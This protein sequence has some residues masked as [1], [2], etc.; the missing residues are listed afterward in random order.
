MY[1]QNINVI[2]QRDY[3]KGWKAPRRGIPYILL[4][5]LLLTVGNFL[6]L[7]AYFV[8]G[9]I[10]DFI[11]RAGG[12]EVSEDPTSAVILTL[13]TLIF[14]N[15]WGVAFIWKEIENRNGLGKKYDIHEK[16]IPWQIP[17]ETVNETFFKM[18]VDIFKQTSE[19]ANIE[20]TKSGS[21]ERNLYLPKRN[22][23]LRIRLH[24]QGKDSDRTFRCTVDMKAFSHPS[25]FT[26]IFDHVGEGHIREVIKFI[27]NIFKSD[28]IRTYFM[29][30]HGSF[31]QPPNI[32]QPPP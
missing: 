26:N 30:H 8:M 1:E 21:L 20:N 13:M 28:M 22:I 32:I 9:V 27:D 19:E 18:L 11:G 5:I 16:A 4:G 10:P 31:F 7:Y 29:Q 15:L 25:S 12:A 2:N 17:R 6:I 24:S 23:R 14:N 3:I